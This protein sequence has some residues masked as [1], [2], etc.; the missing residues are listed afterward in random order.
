MTV[1]KTLIAA[2]VTAIIVLLV[3]EVVSPILTTREVRTAATEVANAGA[4]K[5]FAERNS[6]KGFTLISADAQA[7]A[8]AEAASDHVTLA[9]FTIDASQKVHVTVEKEARSVIFK[10]IKGLRKRDEVSRSTTAAP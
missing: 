2:V 1:L 3:F 8:A 4:A 6:N 7:A 9:A 5:L 10:H